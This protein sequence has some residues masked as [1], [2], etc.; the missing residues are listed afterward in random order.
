ME[1]NKQLDEAKNLIQKIG[2]FLH[3]SEVKE[4]VKTELA[5]VPAKEDAAPVEEVK[6]ESVL[7]DGEY[8][9]ADGRMLV[10]EGGNVTDVK[11]ADPQEEAP[12]AS[13]APAAE[14]EMSAEKSELSSMV[15]EIK[16]LKGQLEKLSAAPKEVTEPISA[17]PKK[18]EKS[19]IELSANMSYKQRVLAQTFNNLK[20]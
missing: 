9:L 13:E 18:A 10:I 19:R 2:E 5:E 12:S 11:E 7:E 14:A 17:A 8:E 20:K 6:A 4:E 16:N 3:L 15:E 1:D